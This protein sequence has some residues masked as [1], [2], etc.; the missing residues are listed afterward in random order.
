MTPIQPIGP[1]P[2]PRAI[3]VIEPVSLALAHVKRVLFQPF[4]LGKWFVIGF[5]AWLAGLGER[6]GG[7]HGSGGGNHGHGSPDIRHG[8]DEARNYLLNNLDWIIP[9]AVVIVLFLFALGLLILWL[10]SRGKFMFL[11]CVALNRAEVSLPWTQYS[12]QGNSL[13]WFRLLLGFLGMILILPLLGI[14]LV[15]VLRMVYHG[16]P[17]AGGILTAVGLGLTFLM[18]AFV[19][20]II[21][22]LTA[23]FVVPIMS[24][25]RCNCLTAW[26]E[27]AG[28]ICARFWLFVLYLLFS[29]VLAIVIGLIVG[30]LMLVTCCVC[31][32]ALLPY[33]GTVLLLPVLVFERAYSLYFFAQFGPE[34]NV[35]PASPP[36]SPTPGLAP[37]PVT[38]STL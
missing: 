5:C 14:I 19:F 37:M 1:Q 24:L 34:Y 2:A 16:A 29:L 21:Q 20:G 7:F 33:I 10:N 31:C 13:F 28:L 22:K 26:R 15:L 38:P 30:A 6:G 9:L 3:S 23:D 4:D 11:H 17:D 18:I 36:A 27:L 35:F 8:L 12:A 32:L 25:R